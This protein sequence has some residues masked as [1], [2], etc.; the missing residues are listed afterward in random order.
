MKSLGIAVLSCALVSSL[1][2]AAS[3]ADDDFVL[4]TVVPPGIGLSA[5]RRAVMG[6]RRR[7]ERPECQRLFAEFTDASG[8]PLQETLDALEQTGPR[9][10]GLILFADA[11]QRPHCKAGG[12]VAFTE[13]GSRVVYVCGPQ[14]KN[15][16]DQNSAKAEA[17]VIHE[18]L[19]SLGL[20]EN[21]PTSEEITA[22]V[23]AR[24]HS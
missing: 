14:L 22:R 5:L 2:P 10:L 3:P 21:P 6:A 20:G 19:H 11:S 4:R 15:T 1:P 9:Y 24:C 13:P 16:V 8:R 18:M 17:V 12:S 7:L 23:L